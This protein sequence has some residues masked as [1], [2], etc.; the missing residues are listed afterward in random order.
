MPKIITR[1]KQRSLRLF[2]CPQTL[3]GVLHIIIERNFLRTEFGNMI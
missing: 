1:R 2:F 3:A